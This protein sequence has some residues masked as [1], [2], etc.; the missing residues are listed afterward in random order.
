MMAYSPNIV[1][2]T[3]GG[4]TGAN[5]GGGSISAFGT[6]V[7]QQILAPFINGLPSN[8]RDWYKQPDGIVSGTGCAGSSKGREIFLAGTEA[9][10]NCAAASPAPTAAPTEAP[11]P[12]PTNNFNP[13]A[14]S[15]VPTGTPIPRP[16]PTR[17]P[18][19]SGQPAA[20]AA[21]TPSPTR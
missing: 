16:T 11:T 9:G 21:P 15:T 17:T 20:V 8:M 4:N 6:E 14:P 7:G 3:W 12:I 2:G 1:V 18:R 13:P 10:T 19:P 5:G